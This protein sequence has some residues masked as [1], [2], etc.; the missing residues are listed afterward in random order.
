MMRRQVPLWQIFGRLSWPHAFAT[1]AASSHGSSAS[2]EMQKKLENIGEETAI[3]YLPA[4]EG[5]VF[6]R[7]CVCDMCRHKSCEPSPLA[8]CQIEGFDKTTWP[9]DGTSE[10]PQGRRCLLCP[11]VFRIAGFQH[12]DIK[13]LIKDMRQNFDLTAQWLGC[14]KQ[15]VTMIGSGKAWPGMRLRGPTKDSS[16]SCSR[17]FG[18]KRWSASGRPKS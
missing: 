18:R 11:W 14:L 9:W 4:V 3:P 8:N 1:M 6:L 13:S 2:E 12:E 5:I 16:R 17:K 7:T 10:D 15:L